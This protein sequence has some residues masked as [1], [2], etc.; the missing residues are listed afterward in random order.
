MRVVLMR[1]N[2]MLVLALV[3]RNQMVAP[4]TPMSRLSWDYAI[5]RISHGADSLYKFAATSAPTTRRFHEEYTL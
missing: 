3:S 1:Q 5:T 2:P 4:P